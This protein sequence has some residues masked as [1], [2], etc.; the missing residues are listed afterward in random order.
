MSI[1][2]AIWTKQL[3]YVKI[4]ASSSSSSQVRIAMRLDGKMSAAKGRAWAPPS[5]LESKYLVSLL[6]SVALKY[7]ASALQFWIYMD[8]LFITYANALN[9]YILHLLDRGHSGP[10]N[11]RSR[12]RRV[13]KVKGL[14]GSRHAKLAA[15]KY[16]VTAVTPHLKK[17]LHTF[18][19]GEKPSLH[20]HQT[21]SKN[22][23]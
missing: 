7:C 14:S 18:N 6:P 15:V 19:R 17:H 2:Y 20:F 8:I 10:V 23:C 4:L 12:A 3:K 5:L 22:L 11:F 21:T 13:F 9:W 1:P 16:S